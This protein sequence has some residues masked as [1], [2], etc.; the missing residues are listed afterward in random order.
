MSGRWKEIVFKGGVFWVLIPV[1]LGALAYFVVGWW[2][3]R[4]KPAP[5]DAVAPIKQPIARPASGEQ[6]ESWSMPDPPQ[7]DISVEKVGDT[8]ESSEPPVDAEPVEIQVPEGEMVDE[9][10][11]GGFVRPPEGGGESGDT[12]DVPPP[13][14]SVPPPN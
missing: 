10:G 3:S 12:G 9:A 6:P 5:A 11:V 7:I 2:T 13:T 14:E 1:T 8:P 4:N